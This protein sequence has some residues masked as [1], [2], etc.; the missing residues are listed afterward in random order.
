MEEIK[1]LQER[2]KKLKKESADLK[3]SIE[4][5]DAD[6]DYLSDRV[7]ESYDFQVDPAYVT[8]KLIDLEDRS[9]G[10]NLRIGGMS[11]CRNET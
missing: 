7:D 2:I 10:N 3:S 1:K 8:S 4:H 5:T 11:E 9:R 6:L